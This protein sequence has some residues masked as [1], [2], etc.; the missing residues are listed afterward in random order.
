MTRV[1]DRKITKAK[2]SFVQFA[3]NSG[4]EF[5]MLLEQLEQIVA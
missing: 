5:S 2:L 3:T 1:S 4:M